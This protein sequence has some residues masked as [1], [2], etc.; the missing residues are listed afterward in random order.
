MAISERRPEVNDGPILMN[1]KP[2]Y[3]DGSGSWAINESEKKMERRSAEQ[4]L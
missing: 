4:N 1:Y 2:E 3:G